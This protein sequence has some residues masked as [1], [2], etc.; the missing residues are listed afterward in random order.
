MELLN[1]S[2]K[3]KNAEY[4]SRLILDNSL[5]LDMLLQGL[6]EEPNWIE[7]NVNGEITYSTLFELLET[8]YSNQKC[9]IFITYI[10][11]IVKGNVIDDIIFEKI[12]C[13]PHKDIREQ[14]LVSLAHKKLK[15]NQLRRLCDEAISFECYYELAILYYTANIYAPEI[16][17]CFIEEILKSKYA[18]IVEEV[19]R[20]LVDYHVASSKK[21]YEYIIGVI[22]QNS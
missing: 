14:L 2:L 13:Y 18:Y 16:L 4:I 17:E 5:N 11:E 9:G 7:D 22:D 3:N 15:E 20:E 12:Y 19:A 21:K 1:Y 10:I 6:E 8:G